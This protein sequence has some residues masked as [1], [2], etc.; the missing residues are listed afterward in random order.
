MTES[1][2]ILWLLVA[3]HLV[4]S[5][6]LILFNPHAHWLDDG[7]YTLTIA[8]NIGQNMGITYGGFPTNGFQP[9][10]GFLIAPLMTVG[11]GH[12]D[13]MIK[14]ALLLMAV[15]SAG[16]MIVLY[17][18]AL[19]LV[20]KRAAIVTAALVAVNANLFTHVLSGL[21]TALHGLLFW[22]FV[23]CYLKYRETPSVKKQALLGILLGLTAYAR[24][25]TVFLFFAVAADMLWRYR[26][27]P[28]RLIRRGLALFA[29]ALVL[30]SPWFIWSVYTFGVFTQSS[31]SF[32]RWRGLVRQDIPESVG[33][34]IKFAVVKLASLGI[35]L[36]LEPL[37][38]YEGLMRLLARSLLGGER[39]Q[40]GFL[41]QLWQQNSLAAIGLLLIGLAVLAVLVVWGREGLRRIVRLRP[42]WFVLVALAGAAVYYPLYQLNYSMRHFFPYSIGLAL[43]LGAF[44]SGFADRNLLR[45]SRVRWV[46]MILIMTLLAAPGLSVWMHNAEPVEAKRISAK[47][48]QYTEP[49]ARIGYTDCGVFGYYAADRVIVNLDGILNFEALHEMQQGDIGDYLVRHD[50]GYVLYLHNFKAE[51]AEQWNTKIA[52]RVQPVDSL[53]WLYRVVG[54]AP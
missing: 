2:R 11:G 28:L 40:T 30:L 13:L 1:K 47:L 33:G 21:E 14:L 49:G 5:G 45:N 25:D 20:D 27:E 29:P 37:F 31:G 17:N 7:Y 18:L 41:W 34:M 36:P 32:H 38:G 35:K 48:S 12:P 39:M 46:V 6:T 16:L 19:K 51:F 3:A 42:L 26:R 52:P 43:L 44:F 23:A 22:L 54:D 8:R 10:Y 50:I 15:C 24:F 53:D 4:L 9:L